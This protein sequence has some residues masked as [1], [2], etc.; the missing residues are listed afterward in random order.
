MGFLRYF[1]AA[2]VVWAH[3]HAEGGFSV[4]SASVA[5]TTFFMISGFYMGLVLDTKYGQHTGI[6]YLSRFL[7]I[8]PLYYLILA[9]ALALFFCASLWKGHPV[10]RLQFYVDA[11]HNGHHALIAFLALI[12][13]TLVG[14]DLPC[15]LSYSAQGAQLLPP[16]GPDFQGILMERM[17]F[18]P[19]AWTIGFEVTFYLLIPFLRRWQTRTLFLIVALSI[20]LKIW[21]RW[22]QVSVDATK[23]DQQFLLP[24]FGFFL[25]GYLA[26]RHRDCGLFVRRLP[27]LYSFL[28]FL[29][30]LFFSWGFLNPLWEQ[31]LWW[32][33]C[34][35]ALPG[36][37]NLSKASRVDAFA[38]SLSY[39]LYLI[40]VPVRWLMLGPG[41]SYGDA[42]SPIWLLFLSTVAAI[43]LAVLFE[44][45]IEGWR[46]RFIRSRF[47][48]IKDASISPR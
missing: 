13:V 36:L 24:Q 48:K 37:F 38:G 26:Y 17:L 41:S 1:L 47:L 30:V 32:G 29:V 42:V 22:E 15:L 7:R 11:W 45:P 35:L 33:T 27:A 34:F 43:L 21:L 9:F 19:H 3:A 8:Y 44:N 2:A 23:W 4:V 20:L 10:D 5:V 18:L 46:A 40:H 31:I 28:G 25:L 12:Q 39:P 6:F 14:I 16:F